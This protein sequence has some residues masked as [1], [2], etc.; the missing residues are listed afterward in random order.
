MNNSQNLKPIYLFENLLKVF[1]LLFIITGLISIVYIKVLL[2]LVQ[3]LCI[4]RQYG[5][6]KFNQQYLVKLVESEFMANI[7]YVLAT[8]Q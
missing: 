3:V 7:L 2:I 1:S 6:I 4:Y 5:M 8:F